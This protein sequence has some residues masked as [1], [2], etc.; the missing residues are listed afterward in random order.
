MD[1]PI[2]ATWNNMYQTGLASITKSDE[3]STFPAQP[4]SIQLTT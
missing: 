4:L 1:D 2:L 3:S